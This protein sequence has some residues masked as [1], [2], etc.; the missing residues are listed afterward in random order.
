[1]LIVLA[2]ASGLIG[3]ALRES[4]Q[5]DGHELR[6]LVRRPAA[7]EH[8]RSWDPDAGRLDPG[9]LAGAD[10]VVNL[11]GAG[12]GDHRWTSSYQRVI[13]DSRLTTTGTIAR[14]IAALGP[15]APATLL[16]ASAVG[17]YG[18][19][20][21][22]VV[23]ES[24]PAG[25]GFLADVCAQWERAT[26]PAESAGHTRV[27]HLRTGLVLARSGGLMGRLVPLVK[28]GLGGKLG[29]GRQYQP[30]ISLADEIGAITHLLTA[31]IAGAVNLTGPT[32]VP[33][34]EFVAQMA[35]ILH[36]P[37]LFPAPGFGLRLVLGR[38]ADEGV[39]AGQRAIPKVLTDSGYDFVHPDLAGALHAALD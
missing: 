16:S 15:D 6:V 23:V 26:A 29:S 18:D 27:A 19:T 17:Y 21:D 5:R 1:M 7:S 37:A 28:A 14:T 39:L 35:A 8:E 4:L 12:V 31:D 38:F 3:S 20:G 10:A 33:Q 13:L 11:S 24:A 34:A 32:P 2:G 36:R 30:W 22:R 9:D 25:A